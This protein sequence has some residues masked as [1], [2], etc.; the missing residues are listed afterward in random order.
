MSLEKK[1]L[2][3]SVN[4]LGKRGLNPLYK[5]ETDRCVPYDIPMKCTKQIK[6][7]N[8]TLTNFEFLFSRDM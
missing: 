1:T 5:I 6:Y 8:I 7:K 2:S 3:V 4:I